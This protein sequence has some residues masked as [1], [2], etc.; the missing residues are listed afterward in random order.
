MPNDLPPWHGRP[1]GS[2][3]APAAGAALPPWAGAPPAA[4]GPGPDPV[5]AGAVL[6]GLPDP[7]VFDIVV[8][9]R[10]LTY[11]PD[12]ARAVR[13]LLAGLRPG[14]P[15]VFQEHDGARERRGDAPARD[16]PERD[17]GDDRARGRRH[18][19]GV[20]Q[21]VE[22]LVGQVSNAWREGVAEHGAGGEDVVGGP[23]PVSA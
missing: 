3:F 2:R 16:G 8:G 14:G 9:R 12:G 6:A 11:R 18:L 20:Q 19:R 22:A 5:E 1:E 7:G 23:P 13:G 15:I 4:D 21:G 17:R 10:A